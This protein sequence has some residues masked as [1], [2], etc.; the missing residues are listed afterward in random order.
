MY[1]GHYSRRRG[2]IRGAIRLTWDYTVEPYVS[3]TRCHTEENALEKVKKTFRIEK[4]VAEELAETAESE[5][6]T[7]TEI[8]EK[9]ITFYARRDAKSG[10]RARENSDGKDAGASPRG[11]FDDGETNALL[12]QLAVK[13][14]QISKLT[15][16]LLNA[17][18]SAKAAQVLHAADVVPPALA[19]EERRENRKSRWRRLA[20]AWRG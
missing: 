17:Q 6:A 1:F 16:A 2:A 12:R 11:G 14:E 9:A 18:G 8:V 7:A 20:E 19:S 5:G 4:S 3:H 13:D 15:E 10:E